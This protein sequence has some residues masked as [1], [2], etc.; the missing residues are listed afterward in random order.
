MPTE[1]TN[2]VPGEIIEGKVQ[3]ITTFGAFIE[4]PG[5]L[6]GLV[7]ISE[8]AD[9]YVKDVKDYIKE[10]DQVKVKVLNIDG[11]KIGLSIKQALP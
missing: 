6:V 2:I 1:Q 10:G 5:G 8:I 4:L 9:T 11:K 7:H 3:G